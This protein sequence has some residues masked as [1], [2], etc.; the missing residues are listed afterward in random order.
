MIKQFYETVLPT[1]GVYCVTTIN[2][3]Y[4]TNKFAE[5]LDELM[6]LI[7]TAKL[8][9]QNVFVALS[10]FKG[11]S[12]K[13]DGAAFARSFFIDLDVEPDNPKKYRTKESALEALDDFL[14][15]ANL[16]PPIRVDSG[17]GVHAYWPLSEDV[18]SATWKRYATKFKALC[19]DYI[20]IDNAVTADAARVLR[21]PDS[22]NYKYDPP[23]EAKFL[24][25]EFRQYHFS[26]FIELLG[27]EQSVAEILAGIVP[28]LE[29]TPDNYEY[30]FADIARKSLLGEGCTQLKDIIMNQSTVSEPMWRAGLSV[31][32]RCVD[33]SD[34]IHK[35]SNKHP[36]YSAD[37]TQAKANETL[38][39]RWSY[40]C[41]KFYELNPEGCEGCAF[42]SQFG[43]AGPIQLGRRFKEIGGVEEVTEADIDEVANN[44]D[45]VMPFPIAIKP[46]VRGANGGV[47][48]VPKPEVDE[49]GVAREAKPIQITEG[50]FFPVKRMKSTNDG[51]CMI[52]RYMSPKDPLEEFAF[53]IS[54]AYNTDKL[55]NLLPAKGVIFSPNHL[56]LIVDYLIKW[57]GYLQKQK[58]ADIMRQQMGWTESLD[59]F[60]TGAEEIRKGGEVRSAVTSPHIK[61]ISKYFKPEGSYELWKEAATYYNRPSME[62]HALGL[63]AGFGSPLMRYTTT[64]G[65]TICFTSPD[66]GVGK[67]AA[68][69][70]GVSI[71]AHPY[72]ASLADASATDNALTGRYLATKN[73]LFGLDEITNIESHALSKLVHK[74]SQ[75]RAKARMQS[76][77]NAEREIEQGAQL[78]ASMTSNQAIY[79]KLKAIKNNPDGEMARVVEF[80]MEKPKMLADNPELGH[81]MVEPFKTNYGHA[82]PIFVKY[83]LTQGDSYVKAVIEKWLTR[84]REDYG[85]KN[86]YRFYENIISACFAGGE[87]AMEANIIDYDLDRIYEVVIKTMIAIRKQVFNINDTDYRALLGEFYNK[88]HTGFIIFDDSKV[89]S[90]PKA[91][92]IVGRIDTHTGLMYISK[93]V[94]HQYLSAPGLQVSIAT[95]EKKWEKEGLLIGSDRK[96]LTTGWKSGTHNNPV[97][98]YIIKDI[99]DLPKDFFNDKAE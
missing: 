17:S 41:D 61:G 69:F 25:T 36:D 90:E 72:Y 56:K 33:G 11:H 65:G 84:F 53:P 79:D 44:D 77:V 81:K 67:T 2:S 9:N 50:D 31:A 43:K 35:I 70:A 7:D 51:E 4:T 82:G 98:C 22:L 58:A 27:E 5:S 97:T 14:K 12:R 54:Y 86:E 88:H 42:R 59:A 28:D 45:K 83:L 74:I 96:R 30:V 29:P 94:M 21:C 76:S 49:D 19:N 1:Q 68:M 64:P 6:G 39:A 18:P 3:S 20:K 40:S 62:L 71:F 57:N 80:R 78:I 89:L 10:S 87:L 92:A 32:V 47:W 75:G 63:L 15:L 73:I 93:T 13:A 24:D 34:S 23:L 91:N 38:N 52:M 85:Y 95:A 60:V 8:A 66:S 48:F 16:P 55:K 26:K 99:P 46:Y 37:K